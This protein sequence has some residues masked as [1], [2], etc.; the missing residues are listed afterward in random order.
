MSVLN[1][2]ALAL[3]VVLWIIQLYIGH[4]VG[5]ASSTP[6]KKGSPEYLYLNRVEIVRGIVTL[7]AILTFI[8]QLIDVPLVKNVGLVILA[9]SLLSVVIL[10]SGLLRLG[11]TKADA[12]ED[13]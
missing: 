2:I 8:S 1:W 7:G 5:M 12:T 3:S 6:M 11:L 9:I 10:W 4:G 13:R